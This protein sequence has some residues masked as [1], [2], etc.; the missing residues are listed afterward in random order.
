MK[1]SFDDKES[2]TEA[3]GSLHF[4]NPPSDPNTTLQQPE[5]GT[6]ERSED[7]GINSLSCDPNTFQ[8]NTS[9]SQDLG[10]E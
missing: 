5:V 3:A 10:E 6:W 7:I 1:L 9:S 4:N 8:R 2:F